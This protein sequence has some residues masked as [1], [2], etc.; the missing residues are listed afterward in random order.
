MKPDD[1][2]EYLEE[3]EKQTTGRE[4]S[5]PYMETYLEYAIKHTDV[6]DRFYTVLARLYIDKLF[7]L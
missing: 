3:I 1:V 2:L 5:F 6:A 7:V 4:D